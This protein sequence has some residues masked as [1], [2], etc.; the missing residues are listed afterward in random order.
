MVTLF[1]FY[2]FNATVFI[3]KISE[4]LK[5]RRKLENEGGVTDHPESNIE[6]GTQA[7]KKIVGDGTNYGSKGLV[8]SGY[9]TEFINSGNT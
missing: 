7:F 5:L 8:D 3:P 4:T 2:Y 1:V 9:A 6:E